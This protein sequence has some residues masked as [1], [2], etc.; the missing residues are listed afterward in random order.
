MFRILCSSELFHYF[1]V[2]FVTV[3]IYNSSETP[4][5]LFSWIKNKN[6]VKP[7]T[8]AEDARHEKTLSVSPRRVIL[9]HIRNM[10]VVSK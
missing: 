9:T 4:F 7:L 6:Y 3:S 2:Y 10:A 8:S 1:C 5:R